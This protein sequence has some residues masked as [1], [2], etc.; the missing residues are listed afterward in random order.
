VENYTTR[1]FTS[2]S[3]YAY[4]LCYDCHNRNSILADESFPLHSEHLAEQ[5]P[6]SACHDAHGISSGQGSTEN[7][8][9]LMN[10]DRVIVGPNDKGFLE[11]IDGG[12]RFSGECS[13]QC[14]GVNH[15]RVVYP[16]SLN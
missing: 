13:V 10:F 2:E 7:N 3:A 9:H 8:T 4:A 12:A 11:F 5:I 1:D 16:S 15:D 14:H 6:C